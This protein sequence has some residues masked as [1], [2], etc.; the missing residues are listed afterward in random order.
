MNRRFLSGLAALAC[1]VLLC[2]FLASLKATPMAAWDDKKPVEERKGAP[3]PVQMK[4][5]CP[6]ANAE[7]AG[8]H[9]HHKG[10]RRCLHPN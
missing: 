10:G 9:A 2:F 8:S 3:A 7:L 5:L 1:G 4:A 6:I